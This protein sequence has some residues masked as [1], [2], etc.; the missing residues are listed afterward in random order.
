MPSPQQPPNPPQYNIRT[1][2]GKHA[3][4]PSVLVDTDADEHDTADQIIENI[5]N[6]LCPRCESPLPTLFPAGSRITKCR[7][8]PI[9]DRCGADEA[10]EVEDT[11]AGI[12]WGGISGASCWP[13]PIKEIEERSARHYRQMTL[14]PMTLTS[15]GLVVT[16]DGSAP[17]II[18]RNTGGWLQYGTAEEA[19]E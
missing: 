13:V 6:G 5:E 19:G 8:I 17:L 3:F 1:L 7:S 18:P 15:D 11:K 4:D 9:C 10:F 2:S 12:G 14:M 16:E